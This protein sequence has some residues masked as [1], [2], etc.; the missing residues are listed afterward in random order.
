MSDLEQRVR[1]A[2]ATAPPGTRPGSAAFWR[3]LA[4]NHAEL[5][6][7]HTR[8]QLIAAARAGIGG[9]TPERGV[10]P[11]PPRGGSTGAEVARHHD[12]RPSTLEAECSAGHPTCAEPA[13]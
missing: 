4:V 5:R 12:E 1:L 3:H 2:L 7:A 13:Q 6:A 9:L 10:L 8:R 11:P